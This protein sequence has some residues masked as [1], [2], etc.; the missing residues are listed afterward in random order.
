MKTPVP[1]DAPQ[2]LPTDAVV[3]GGGVMG[4]QIAALLAN[5]GV[6][7]DLLDL[8][9]DDDPA[10]LARQAIAELAR[11]RP[12]PLFRAADAHRIRPGALDDAAS[13]L[14]KTPW[15]IEAVVEDLTIKRGV[16]DAVERHAH[17]TALISTNTSGLSIANLCE[18]R[19]K[20]FCRRFVGIHFF[21]PPRA[22][23]L[24]EV[25]PGA[26]TDADILRTSRDWIESG[27]GKRVV[28]CR[29]TPNFIANRLGVFALMDALHRMIEQGLSVD[30]VDAVTGPLLGRPR[31]A[32]L[33]LCDLIGL[34]TLA[35]VAGTA[36]DGLAA[37]PWRQ[38]FATPP[39]LQ[40]MLDAGQLGAKSG[41]GFFTR[42]DG[43]IL[44][45]D[46]ATGEYG[47]RQPVSL[48]LP[49]RGP[50]AERLNS[51][52]EDDSDLARFAREHVAVSVAYAAACAGEVAERLEDV[53]RGLMWGFNWEAG[54]LAMIDLIGATRLIETLESCAPVI[55]DLLVQL[56]DDQHTIYRSAG[57][58]VTDL[59]GGYVAVTAAGAIDDADYLAALP[60]VQQ[61]EGARLLD[62]GD[63]VGVLQFHAGS[64]NVLGG[65][66]LQFAV[67]VATQGKSRA[68]VL[69]GAGENLSAGADL[70]YL[71]SLINAHN[72]Q[73]LEAYLVLFQT[74][75]S[76]MR[77]A[78]MPVVVAPRGL[79]L[80]GGCEFALSG[81]ARV[82]AAEL[83]LGLVEAKVGLIPGAGGC[84]EVVRRVGPQVDAIFDVIR[85]GSMSDNARQAQDWGLLDAEDVVCMDGH[86]VIQHAVHVAR[87][88]I[89]G[90]AVP[91]ATDQM[92][93]GSAGLERLTGLLQTELAAG[94]ATE[95]DV[96][97]GNALARVLCGDGE[98]MVS[99]D[100]LL[101]LEREHFLR[102][103]GMTATRERIAHMLDTGKPIR[104]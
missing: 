104:N 10:G 26:A 70:Q 9:T 22:M 35:H 11:M 53:D 99:E 36:F 96:T 18:G 50:L 64:L 13:V 21:N 102:L 77:Y 61:G 46:L 103:C 57:R 4:R 93:A 45:R 95:H 79:A 40:Q 85:A 62:A 60:T 82:A 2:D 33:R 12:A 66:A 91:E 80:G 56:A 23:P 78:P 65:P 98:E 74:A 6:T 52:W 20:D 27:L 97:V 16:L 39:P 29:D 67:D 5:A 83:R 63:G 86:R 87:G 89:P 47:P 73:E 37:D 7:V 25:I 8:G 101:E 76:T 75:T 31:S 100:R 94:T 43:Q 17:P 49:T 71:L 92:T 51:L 90:W 72:W 68:L 59:Q 19:S 41:A 84:K 1:G 69:G 15:V 30:A 14:A 81:G 34:D 55:P 44:S 38:R 48:K 42:R 3:L 54:P 28:I 32:T 58:E 88:L 24:V